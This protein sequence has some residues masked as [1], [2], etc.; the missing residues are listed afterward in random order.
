[1]GRTE[2]VERLLALEPIR[3]G[4]GLQTSPSQPLRLRFGDVA[5]SLGYAGRDEVEAALAVQRLDRVGGRPHRLLGQIL[6]DH[7]VM[8]QF[9]V[10][11]VLEV[12]VREAFPQ[13]VS[14]LVTSLAC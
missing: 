4:A 3:D 11:Q 14:H 1:M 9:Q 13:Q 7:K 5:V 2:N 12:L 10:S 6:V 8:T